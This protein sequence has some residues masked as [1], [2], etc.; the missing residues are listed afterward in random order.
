MN[1][2]IVELF[3]A[4]EKLDEMVG[5]IPIKLT[6]DLSGDPYEVQIDLKQVSKKTIVGHAARAVDIAQGT[7]SDLER[8]AA[9]GL[10]PKSA[11]EDPDEEDDQ[12]GDEEEAA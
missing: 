2:R 10:K 4:V 1:E 7:F 6:M 9:G 8:E 5:V 3:G 12:D 11:Q